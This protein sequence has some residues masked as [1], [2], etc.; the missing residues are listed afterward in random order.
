M[1]MATTRTDRT[2]KG[3]PAAHQERL[4]GIYLNDHLMGATGGVELARRF[5]KAH[6]A[7]AEESGSGTPDSRPPDHQP[8]ASEGFRQVADEI[9]E[10]RAALLRIMETLKVPIRRYKAG[11]GW[12]AEKVGRL[13]SNGSILRRS[14]LSDLVELEALRTGVEGKAE[15]WR[16]LRTLA[17][18]DER[19]DAAWLDNLLDRA[20]RQS[21]TLEE[22]RLRTAARVF[23]A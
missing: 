3:A 23:A 20:R 9:V 19:L 14:P 5:L 2:D 1:P 15:A 17:D 6:P 22:L 7:P 11:V 12:I 10:D 18:S 13:K 16:V 21:Q 4:L 8:S